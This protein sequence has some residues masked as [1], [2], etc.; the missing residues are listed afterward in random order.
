MNKL[1]SPV[2]VFLF[3]LSQGG[4]ASQTQ[5]FC[6]R[7]LRLFW[8]TF[9]FFSSSLQAPGVELLV[10]GLNEASQAVFKLTVL[11][12]PEINQ[13]LAN[14]QLPFTCCHTHFVGGLRSTLVLPEV[15]QRCTEIRKSL[16]FVFPISSH[17][18]QL[19]SKDSTNKGRSWLRVTHRSTRNL[20][21][22][23][24]F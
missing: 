21:A 11:L 17:G 12:W 13:A 8:S 4:G 22:S 3:Q 5:T 9:W 15:C 6:R 19:C 2:W 24:G 1:W 20:F 16:D 7:F 14:N 18:E 10:V 23:N